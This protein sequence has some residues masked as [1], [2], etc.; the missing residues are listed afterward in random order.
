MEPEERIYA[1]LSGQKPDRIPTLSLSFDPN[2]INQVFRLPPVP[3]LQVINSQ[4]MSDFLDRRG[5]TPENH[6]IFF[7]T[8]MFLMGGLGA[9][10]NYRIGFDGFILPY[11]RLKFRNH[12]QAEDMFG[13]VYDIVDDGY[14]NPYYM[15]HEGL[16]K[17]PEE[18]RNWPRP[19]IARYAESSAR[20]FRLWRRI[21]RKRIAVIP[22]VMPGI[23]ENGWQP[24]GFANFVSLMRRDP[25]FVREVVGYFTTLTDAM[26]DAYCRDGAKVVALAD[27]L[28][29]KAGLLLSPDMLDEFYAPSY[30]QITATAHR[31]GARIIF[32][33]CGNTNEIVERFVEWGFDG[34]HAFEPTAMNDL[35]E[36]RRRAGNRLCLI[37]NIDVTHTLVDGTRE[38][39]EAEVVKAV[40]DSAGGGFILAPAHTHASIN[41][42]NLRWMLEAAT[43]LDP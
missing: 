19:G 23:W 21:W 18:W 24:M 6:G 4:K 9:Q 31:H 10:M 36:A 28:G 2:I 17:T 35:A 16:I 40:G 8:V 22:W 14:G 15:Y 7:T 11:Y 30:R 1:A 5:S 39:V 27:D 12:A 32:H 3:A 33:C 42:R 25:G 13:R 43:N 38:E 26:I 37:G 29:H 41:A 20:L 34:A